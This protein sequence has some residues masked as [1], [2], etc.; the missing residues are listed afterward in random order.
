VYCRTKVLKGHYEYL[1]SSF[2]CILVPGV[3][4]P[5]VLFWFLTFQVVLFLVFLGI[6]DTLFRAID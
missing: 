1:L 6:G 4:A 3:L 2:L 5:S